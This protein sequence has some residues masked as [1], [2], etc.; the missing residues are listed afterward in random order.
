[1]L[2][3]EYDLVSVDRGLVVT[4]QNG[5]ILVDWDDV[6]EAD[7]FLFSRQVSGQSDQVMVVLLPAGSVSD[8]DQQVE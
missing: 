7:Y 6:P 3:S 1:M 4:D 2:A 8:L 5:D